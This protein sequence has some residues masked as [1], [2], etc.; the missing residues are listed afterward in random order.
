M[1]M[2]HHV[3]VVTAVLMWP[4]ASCGHALMSPTTS[5]RVYLEAKGASRTTDAVRAFVSPVRVGEPL[6][7][8]Q[9]SHEDDL[10]RLYAS[11]V[12]SGRSTHE[13]VPR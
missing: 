12:L 11:R 5:T 9:R 1:T 3:H 7:G 4:G 13:I 6:A 2:T 8:A 10:G